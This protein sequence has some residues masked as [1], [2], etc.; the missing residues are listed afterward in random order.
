M[1]VLAMIGNNLFQI[2]NLL[3]MSAGEQ[4]L[5][6][7]DNNCA[8]SKKRAHIC[9]CVTPTYSPFG[10]ATIGP[11]QATQ[12]HVQHFSVMQGRKNFR[13]T[14]HYVTQ[15]FRLTKEPFLAKKEACTL[16][17]IINLSPGLSLKS[18]LNFYNFYAQSCLKYHES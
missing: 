5:I 2:S 4:F 6:R 14:Q 12:L 16:F 18:C 3:V 7:P 1:T 9:L 13:K 8:N 11:S 17:F 15:Q 10:G